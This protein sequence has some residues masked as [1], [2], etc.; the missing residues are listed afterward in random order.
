MKLRINE[1]G[2]A[3][4]GNNHNKYSSDYILCSPVICCMTLLMDALGKAALRNISY[5][6]SC[7]SVKLETSTCI[8]SRSSL[9]CSRRRR[10]FCLRRPSSVRGS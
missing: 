5:L 8:R 9:S 3:E 6:S 2:Y 7:P 10:S 4:R 1:L